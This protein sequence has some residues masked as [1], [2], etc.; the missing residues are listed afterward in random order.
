MQ[1]IVSAYSVLMQS[2]STAYALYQVADPPTMQTF[3]HP[4]LAQKEA[5]VTLCVWAQPILTCSLFQCLAECTQGC[6]L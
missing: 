3:T 6:R 5:R 4:A 2:L 1:P